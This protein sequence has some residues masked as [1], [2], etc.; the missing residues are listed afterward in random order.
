MQN[1]LHEE[2]PMTHGHQSVLT[3]REQKGLLT[4]RAEG[5]R[6]VYS[7]AVEHRK[8]TRSAVKQLLKTYFDGSLE[9]AVAAMLEIHEGDMTEEDLARLA[10]IVARAKKEEKHDAANYT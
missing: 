8:A 4:H 7:P 5:K 9:K 6:Y 10:E 3:R 1:F 2:A